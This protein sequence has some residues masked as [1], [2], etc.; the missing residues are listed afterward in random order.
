MAGDALEVDGESHGDARELELGAGLHHVRVSRRNR[1]VFATFTEV[2]EGQRALTLAAPTIEPCSAEDLLATVTE[3]L[4]R[5]ACPRW[6]KVRD[7]PPGIGVA[8]CEHERC[9]AFV[10]WQMPAPTPFTP[11]AP[12]RRGMP[13]WL[14][15]AIAGATVVATG[16]LVLWQ[17]GAFERGR[18]SAARWEYGGLDPQGL[19]F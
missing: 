10:H 16:S 2:I 9:G 18:P 15:F 19:R 7:E 12:E 11:L 1:V 8:Q 4:P 13:A 6:V 5:V 17:A 14:G 3:A